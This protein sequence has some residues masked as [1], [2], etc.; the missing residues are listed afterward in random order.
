MRSMEFLNDYSK[1]FRNGSKFAGIRMRLPEIILRIV[2]YETGLPPT[3]LEW[4]AMLGMVLELDRV[5]AQ[6][7]VKAELL[8]TAHQHT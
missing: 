4:L 7:G 8:L 6:A 5:R 1:R 2:S 3:S